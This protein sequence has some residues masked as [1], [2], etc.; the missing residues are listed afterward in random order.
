MV[1]ELVKLHGGTI[2]AFSKHGVGSKF[3]VTMQCGK[4]YFWGIILMWEGYGHLPIER[5]RLGENMVEQVKSGYSSR[6]EWWIGGVCI[7]FFILN[8]S[9]KIYFF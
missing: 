7:F 9:Q 5:V 2:Q 8:L 4:R 1:S 6:E 3:V